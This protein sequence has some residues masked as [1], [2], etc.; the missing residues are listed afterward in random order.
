MLSPLRSGGGPNSCRGRRI[1]QPMQL[2]AHRLNQLDG[3]TSG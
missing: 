2:T 3:H 1:H